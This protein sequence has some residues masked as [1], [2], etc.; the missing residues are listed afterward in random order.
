MHLALDFKQYVVFRVSL[1]NQPTRPPAPP[2][3]VRSITID[4]HK[5]AILVHVGKNIVEDVLL[6]GGL[7]VNIITEDLRK[8]WGLPI[9]K[10]APDTL[11][12]V[13]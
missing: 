6:D 9:L 12:M 7:G 5:A 10:L 8:K 1:G 3:D 11:R 4:L 2:F 13:N